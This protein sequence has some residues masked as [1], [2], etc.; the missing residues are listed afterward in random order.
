MISG[1]WKLCCALALGLIGAGVLASTKPPALPCPDLARPTMGGACESAISA[2]LEEAE[3]QQAV[4]IEERDTNNAQTAFFRRA[5]ATRVGMAGRRV[6]AAH[7]ADMCPA[8]ESSRAAIGRL[9]AQRLNEE[10]ATVTP[11]SNALHRKLLAAGH[12][13]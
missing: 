10:G 1:K 13:A 11:V 9:I 6:P 4:Q 8:T 12:C 7:L 5:Y 3:G 2:M